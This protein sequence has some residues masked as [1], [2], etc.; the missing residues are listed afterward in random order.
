MIFRIEENGAVTLGPTHEELEMLYEGL[1]AASDRFERWM[2]EPDEHGCVPAYS[3]RRRLERDNAR[4]IELSRELSPLISEI[5]K[6]KEKESN[7]C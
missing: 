1:D 6:M 2:T 3:V 4:V 5:R 7:V